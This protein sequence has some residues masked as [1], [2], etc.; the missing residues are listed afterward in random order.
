VVILRMPGF[1]RRQLLRRVLDNPFIIR[2]VGG[3]IDVTA[4]G[5]FT[6]GGGWGIPIHNHSLMV[7]VG[8]IDQKVR[9]LEG[10]FCV[11]EMLSLT[12]SLDHDIIDGSPAARFASRL[13][14]LVESASGLEVL[15]I[16]TPEA[17]VARPYSVT[18]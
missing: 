18:L 4:I 17:E 13:K 16:P 2:Q 3:T 9:Q 7:T 12:L 14:A 15:D 8:G 5:M 11:R 1:I 6:K 10:Q